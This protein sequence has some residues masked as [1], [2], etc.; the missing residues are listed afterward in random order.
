MGNNLIL[1]GMPG[2]GK[3]TVGVLLAKQLGLDFID[4]DLVLQRQVGLRLQQLINLRGLHN[5]R[6]AEEQMLLSL[7]CDHAVIATGGSVIYSE[8][9][10]QRLKTL[11]RV[12]YLKI[13]LPQLTQRIANMGQRGLMKQAGQSF[14]D[15]YAER[16]PRYR[17]FADIEVD[18]NGLGTEAVLQKVEKQ[19]HTG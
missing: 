2:A 6:A 9:G 12:V 7:D 15:L 1:I 8:P 19:L 13:D 17:R 5:F 10:M 11:G 3:S 4:T 16:T 18:I 14:A